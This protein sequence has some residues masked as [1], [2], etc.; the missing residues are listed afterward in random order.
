MKDSPEKH[1][2]ES[3]MKSLNM[4]KKRTSINILILST[5]NICNF[6]IYFRDHK[7]YVKKLQFIDDE[8]L[9]VKREEKFTEFDE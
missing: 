7:T 9:T 1:I 3:I 6:F 2:E 5:K 8:K 4:V